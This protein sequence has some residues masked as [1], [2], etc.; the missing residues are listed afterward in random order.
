MLRASS[1]THWSTS[2][3]AKYLYPEHLSK[4][5]YLVLCPLDKTY[6]TVSWEAHAE[7]KTRPLTARNFVLL[8]GREEP[9]RRVHR[10]E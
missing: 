8:E 5:L 6:Q 1:T 3:N 10:G 2:V 4:S 7:T 9:I